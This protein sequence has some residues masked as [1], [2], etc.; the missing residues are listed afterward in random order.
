FWA[1][2]VLRYLPRP[3]RAYYANHARAPKGA[4]LFP[5]PPSI[6]K[7]IESHPV[8]KVLLS[9]APN[10]QAENE[11]RQFYAQRQ[12]QP[13]FLCVLWVVLE[14]LA[15]AQAGRTPAL[16]PQMMAIVRR[17]LLMFPLSQM[18]A[19]TSA[20]VDFI[21]ASELE[22]GLTAPSAATKRLL[23][24]F[25]FTFHLI[26]HEHVLF[27]LTR[28][29]HDLRRDPLRMALTRFVL[30]ESPMFSERLNEW[31]RLDFRGRYWADHDHATKHGAFMAKFPEY[32]EYEA[33]LV[34]SK[35]PLEPPP[36][37][38]LPI[39]YENIMV[40][41]LPVLEFALGR[42]IEAEDK[43]L[44][45]DVLDRMGILYRLHQVPLT[46]LMDTLFIYFAAPTLHDAAVLRSLNLSLLDLTQ[47]N[48]SSEFEQFVRG[49]SVPSVGRPYVGRMMERIAKAITRHLEKPPKN[50]LPEIHYREIPNPILLV[51]TECVV[52]LLTWWCL[53]CADG[54][55]STAPSPSTESEFQREEQARMKRAGAWPLAQVWFDMVMDRDGEREK[56]HKSTS[57]GAGTSPTHSTGASY[58]HSTGVLV[59][60]MPDELMAFPYVQKL[61]DIVLTEPLLKTVSGPK[62]Y[63]SF[64]DFSRDSF[65]ASVQSNTAFAATP[66]FNSFELNRNRNMANAPNTYL[67]LLHSILHYGGIGTFGTLASTIHGLA[68]GG[69]LCTDTQLLYLCAT[70]GPIL[71][72][73][74]DH[75]ALYVQIL[76]DLVAIMAQVC[77]RLT[78]LDINTSTE[79]IEQ[80]MDFFCFV[81]DQFDPG[82][83][84][85][86][87]IAP[88]ISALPSL[89][90]YQLQG[91]VDQQ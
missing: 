13:V 2:S 75:D 80:V 86:R 42:L 81:K 49:G 51:L 54:P 24:D 69:Q 88:H 9:A 4:T 41:L 3:V 26:H 30:L 38:S 44:L 65:R 64:V 6:R 52:E 78:A 22:R 23:D 60:V 15:M 29:E 90:R 63:F 34:K 28:G 27:A 56:E 85:W 82:R 73:L 47:Q 32:F 61:A 14:R 46:T 53:H 1:P 37:L 11:L 12:R 74:V 7:L 66:V 72:R 19:Y 25:T 50:D 39:Y 18:S 35:V 20:L 77:P 40:R 43:Q 58:I 55:A 76:G 68:A 36:A 5:P 91:I 84:A 16:P 21:V 87:R 62:Q 8:H 48:F 83:A 79:A 17:V 89:L 59:N 70:V 57:S 10:P 31:H 45:R 71:Y 67:T 33:H